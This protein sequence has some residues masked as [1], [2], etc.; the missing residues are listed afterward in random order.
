MC[1][2]ASNS[3]VKQ[4]W[5]NTALGLQWTDEME[6]DSQRLGKLCEKKEKPP[7]M[8]WKK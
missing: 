4:G 2:G 8:Q 6:R 5:D 7:I 3:D 1:D